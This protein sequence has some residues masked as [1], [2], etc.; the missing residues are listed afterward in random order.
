MLVSSL[1]EAMDVIRG[2]EAGADNFLT[3]PYD[4][5][6][7]VGR[8]R[9]I[10]DNR[11]IRLGRKLSVG[12]EVVF[13]GK[14]FTITSEKEQILDLLMSTFEDTVRANREL[15]K[16]RSEL[17]A[18]K[19]KLEEYALAPREPRSRLRREVR[20]AF[21]KRKQRNLALRQRGRDPRS[22]S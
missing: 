8:V 2:L 5:H 7:L 22:Q 10:L 9:A 19:E 12:I 15:Q 21:G 17:G 20:D 6:H 16:H 3:K 18:A 4:E 14:R 13:L 11:A 1:S